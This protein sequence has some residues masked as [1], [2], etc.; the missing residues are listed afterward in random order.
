[1][2]LC[3]LTMPAIFYFP[4][5]PSLPGLP[6]HSD[7]PGN[8]CGAPSRVFGKPSAAR[9]VMVL[10]PAEGDRPSRPRPSAALPFA[11][12][13]VRD[14]PPPDFCPH[15]S[16]SSGPTWCWAF[17]PHTLADISSDPPP[18]VPTPMSFS[19][20]APTVPLRTPRRPSPAVWH[21]L[22]GAPFVR[23]SALCPATGAPSAGRVE[24]ASSFATTCLGDAHRGP[25]KEHCVLL[26]WG[27]PASD[28]THP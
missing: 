23:P 21:R 19:P 20:C 16:S 5:L 1:M 15:W 26:V 6:Q 9:R 24:V 27:T 8:V 18:R 28:P 25:L 2:P 13:F 11:P 22:W 10:V 7:I 14:P 17:Q 12:C 4:G 3:G